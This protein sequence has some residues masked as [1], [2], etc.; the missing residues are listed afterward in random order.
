LGNSI[1]A[2]HL[3]DTSQNK[4]LKQSKWRLWFW[5]VIEYRKS[6]RNTPELLSWLKSR[7]VSSVYQIISEWFIK[8]QKLF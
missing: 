5:Q 3:L 4:I 7:S 2:K 1:I 8:L 6:S